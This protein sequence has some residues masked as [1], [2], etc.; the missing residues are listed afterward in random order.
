MLIPRYATD[1]PKFKILENTPA[2]L[3]TPSLREKNLCYE[4]YQISGY[5]ASQ[6]KGLTTV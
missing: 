5:T 1:T 4:E 3:V 2:W 6:R